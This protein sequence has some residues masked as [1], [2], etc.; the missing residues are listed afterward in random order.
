M[1][2]FFL[3][4]DYCVSL[5]HMLPNES[6]SPPLAL[7]PTAPTLEQQFAQLATEGN[8]DNV[9]FRIQKRLHCSRRMGLML[10]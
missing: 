5:A 9:R 7:I 3:G 10:W 6:H 8:D 2:K 1:Q 4:L